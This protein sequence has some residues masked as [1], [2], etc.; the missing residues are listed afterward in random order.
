VGGWAV[1]ALVVNDG[2]EGV[3]GPVIAVDSQ[4][5]P[6]VA[7]IAETP[8]GVSIGLVHGYRDD[9]VWSWETVDPSPTASGDL[10]IAVDDGGGVHIAYVESSTTDLRYAHGV[11]GTWNLETVDAP[12]TVGY[13]ASLDLQPSGD[14]A[15]AYYDYDSYQIKYA[16]SSGGVWSTEVAVSDFNVYGC[17]SLK[18]AQDGTPHMAYTT[19][20]TSKLAYASK[21]GGVWLSEVVTPAV[22]DM[23]E[24]ASLALDSGEPDRRRGK[25]GLPSRF[26]AGRFRYRP[27]HAHAIESNR[28][29]GPAVRDQNR[30]RGSR[31]TAGPR[32]NPAPRRP[33]SF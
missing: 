6:H 15:I 8:A 26:P 16:W 5:R 1:E 3:R 18:I 24:E 25:G 4:D 2:F 19:T 9:E 21:P 28:P 22:G 11:G 20:T 14:P 10:A 13:Y 7:Y 23:G 30:G 29:R 32:G 31:S 17:A 27:H 33:E 12:G